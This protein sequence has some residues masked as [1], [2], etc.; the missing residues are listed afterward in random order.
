MGKRTVR[1]GIDVGGTFTD[2]V[3][4]DNDTYEVIAKEKVPTTHHA[5]QGVAAG[6]VQAIENVLTKNQISPDDVV[7]IAH[8]TTQATNALLEGDVAKVG[9]IGMG[10]GAGS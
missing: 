10:K 2:A 6:I 8:G 3:V 4:V 9:V 1:I 5:E 7:F